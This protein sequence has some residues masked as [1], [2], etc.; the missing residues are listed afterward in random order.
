MDFYIIHPRGNK[1][2]IDVAQA[3]SY[4]RDDYDLASEEFFSE[5]REAIDF[6]VKLAL[7]HNR[8][9]V[10]DRLDKY[11]DT[12]IHEYLASP[13][14]SNLEECKLEIKAILE[15]HNCRIVAADTYTDVLIQELDTH[16]T[17]NI[18]R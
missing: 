12:I 9:Y 7:K 18:G 10:G 11:G 15:K 6:A 14:G 4:E 1:T 5:R 2:Q 3:F 13:D 8:K 16:D 17:V